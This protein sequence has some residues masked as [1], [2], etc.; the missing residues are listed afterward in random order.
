[1]SDGA[2]DLVG[3]VRAGQQAWREL[4]AEVGDRVDEP[5]P[6]GEWTFGDLAGHLLAWRNRTIARLEAAGRREPEPA[7]PWPAGLDDDDVINDW[8]RQQDQGRSAADLI[9]AYDQSFGRL[10]KAVEVLPPG[11]VTDPE[12][13][14]W[15]EGTPLAQVDPTSHLTEEHEPA[16]RA[17]LGGRTA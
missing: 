13:F 12:A 10:A 17:W 11:M 2:E 5:G 15:L 14:P 8:F 1:M 16:I 6:M 7:S 9:A 3:R 4:V